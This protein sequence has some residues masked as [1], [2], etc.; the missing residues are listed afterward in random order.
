M[1]S[2]KELVDK[3]RTT[4]DCYMANPCGLPQ[5]STEHQLPDDVRE[6]YEICGGASLFENTEVYRVSILPPAE[7]VLANPVIV[8]PDGYSEEDLK[9]ISWSWYLI[10]R[11]DNGEY[12]TIDFS[13]QR[14]GRCYDSFY[15]IHAMAGSSPIIALS[16]TEL[17]NRLYESQGKNQYWESPDFVSL[18]DAYDDV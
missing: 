9:D 4:P 14:L 15:E 2:I 8:G 7:V 5:I 18:G 11:D 13:K 12:L 10:A 1:L 6:F 17:L 3:T 16:F